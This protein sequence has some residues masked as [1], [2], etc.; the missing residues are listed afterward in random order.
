VQTYSTAKKTKL[1]E[2]H[3]PRVDFRSN[4]KLIRL[5]DLDGDG[6]SELAASVGGG[7]E[8]L[9]G[10]T[11]DRLHWLKPPDEK[12]NE[13]N[14]GY[15]RALAGLGSVDGNGSTDLAISETDGNRINGV[16]RALSGKTAEK[17]W[18]TCFDNDEN[19]FQFGFAMATLGDVNGDK[20]SDL[21]VGS[22]GGAGWGV[23]QA[24]VISGKDG[25]ALFQFSR[26]GGEV[27]VTKRETKAET[28]R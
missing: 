15:G 4:C 18:E 7:V 9:H 28:P 23:G 20:I 16:V 3:A 10:K 22:W 1:W 8:V 24:R 11:G 14:L 25:T 13:T 21:I 5:G 6:V 2:H 12:D 26:K 17:R 27:V 19:L